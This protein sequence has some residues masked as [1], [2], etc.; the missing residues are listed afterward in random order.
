[1]AQGIAQQRALLTRRWRQVAAPRLAETAFQIQLVSILRWALR[2]DV[3]FWHTP[4]GELRDPRS[5]AKLKAMGTL[6]GVSDLQLHWVEVD[7]LRRKLC[8]VLHLELKVGNHQQSNAQLEFALA[9]KCLGHDYCVVR[10]VDEAIA[11]LEM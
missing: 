1:M 2:P 3:L 4:N 6:P 9:V 5:A 11:E 8:R 10:S 7:A